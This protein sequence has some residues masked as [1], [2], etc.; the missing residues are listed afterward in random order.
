LNQPGTGKVD[1]PN[2]SRL[3]WLKTAAGIAF[4]ALLL[5][6]VAAVSSRAGATAE[7]SSRAEGIT[8]GEERQFIS[9]YQATRPGIVHIH[10]ERN[11]EPAARQQFQADLLQAHDFAGFSGRISDPNGGSGFVLDSDGYIVT[12]NRVIADATTIDVTFMDGTVASARLIGRDPNTDLAILQVDKLPDAV[13]PLALSDSD[14]LQVGQRVAALGDPLG[15]GSTMTVGIISAKARNVRV[16]IQA[17]DGLFTAPDLLQTDAAITAGMTGGALVNLDGDVVGIV[18]IDTWLYDTSD[19]QR[20]GGVGLCIPTTSLERVLPSLLTE[21]SYRYPWLGVSA[22]SEPLDD[23]LAEAIG[24]PEG[25]FGV[26]IIDVTPG[27]PAAKAGLRGGDTSV[28]DIEPGLQIG[29]DLVIGFEGHEV[30]DFDQLVSLL[31]REGTVGEAITLTIIRD[32]ET[33]DVELVL[34]ERP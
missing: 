33:M 16:E 20:V 6:A 3:R 26:L 25:Q 10:T 31:F 13:R 34:E 5:T 15:Y 22:H 29:G 1:G 17:G 4:A 24:V 27:S 28:P 18:G 32:G 30:H 7:V 11:G 2:T 21:G 14:R 23:E 9:L 12:T 8:D 19:E